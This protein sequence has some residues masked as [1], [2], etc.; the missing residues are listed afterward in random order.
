MRL[1]DL[2]IQIVGKLDLGAQGFHQ[3]GDI[4]VRV[5]L[6]PKDSVRLYGTSEIILKGGKRRD[7]PPLRLISPP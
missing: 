6:E 1:H 7:F 5:P 3:I 4:L 2:L